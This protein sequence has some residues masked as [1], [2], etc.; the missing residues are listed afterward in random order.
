M[1]TKTFSEIQ[2]TSS[3]DVLKFY[4]FAASSVTADRVSWIGQQVRRGFGGACDARADPD[5][6]MHD[7]GAR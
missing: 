4:S 5:A 2:L 3:R 7:G 6:A 1:S